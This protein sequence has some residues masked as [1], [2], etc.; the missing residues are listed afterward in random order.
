MLVAL[1]VIGGTGRRRQLR[2]RQQTAAIGELGGAV[3][4]GEIAVVADAVEAALD[5]TDQTAV[6]D[7]DAM[8]ITAE[9][10]E[11]LLGSA[12]R[13][14][15]IDDPGSATQQ[16]GGVTERCKRSRGLGVLAMTLVATRV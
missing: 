7:G 15:G 12:E 13:S 5:E 11:P 3:T 9:I 14:L 10:I 4:V 1:A 8:G 2:D 16:A 6:G